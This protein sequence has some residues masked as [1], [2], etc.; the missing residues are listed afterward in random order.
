MT[1]DL[2]KERIVY[3][4][5]ASFSYK[6]ENLSGLFSEPLETKYLRNLTYNWSEL[7]YPLNSGDFELIPGPFGN[8]IISRTR[9]K[10]KP[11]AWLPGIILRTEARSLTAPGISML[12]CEKYPVSYLSPKPSDDVLLGLEREKDD[13]MPDFSVEPIAGLEDFAFVCF[14]MSG[15][16]KMPQ[17]LQPIPNLLKSFGFNGEF[18][19][20]HPVD[21]YS[22]VKTFLKKW[23][24]SGFWFRINLNRH[25]AGMLMAALIY[26]GSH[27]KKENSRL[28]SIHMIT[29]LGEGYG[30]M[31]SKWT[32]QKLR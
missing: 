2:L 19:E 16:K 20:S 10:Q 13:P 25:D 29:T 5:W 14:S 4:S 30:P 9:E 21:A 8:G 28:R 6:W 32:M 18:L 12:I 26:L 11:H 15:M 22:L 31:C 24:L 23:N 17:C 3:P 7:G 27:L 1:F